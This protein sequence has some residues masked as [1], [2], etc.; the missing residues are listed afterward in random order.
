MSKC[1]LCEAVVVSLLIGLGNVYKLC[2]RQANVYVSGSIWQI[3]I[4]AAFVS[5]LPVFSVLRL[6]GEVFL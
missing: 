6:A 5:H 1:T 4:F 3:M 2:M